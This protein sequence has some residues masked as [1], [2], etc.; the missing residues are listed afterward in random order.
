MAKLLFQT[1]A[2]GFPPPG[3]APLHSVASLSPSPPRGRF[4]QGLARG[5]HGA[6][7]QAPGGAA[8]VAALGPRVAGAGAQHLECLGRGESRSLRALLIG[9][10]RTPRDIC[11]LCITPC[12]FPTYGDKDLLWFQLRPHARSQRM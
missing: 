3:L 10:L 11:V 8:G 2:A 12:L 5:R 4:A 1:L 9:W 6:A 7:L